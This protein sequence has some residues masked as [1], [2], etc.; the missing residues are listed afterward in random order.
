MINSSKYLHFPKYCFHILLP[1]LLQIYHLSFSYIHYS[2]ADSEISKQK[3]EEKAPREQ[4][5][6]SIN[7]ILDEMRAE[8]EAKKHDED[9]DINKANDL[10]KNLKKS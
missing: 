2:K 8:E 5:N 7:E 3:Y 4:K 10:I 6:K 9:F 1:N